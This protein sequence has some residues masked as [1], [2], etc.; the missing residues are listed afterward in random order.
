MEYLIYGF[1]VDIRQYEIWDITF[2]LL[3]VCL[4][5]LT[6]GNYIYKHNISREYLSLIRTGR[7]SQWWYQLYARVLGLDFVLVVLAFVLS[8]TVQAGVWKLPVSQVVGGPVAQAFVL[9]F[10]NICSLSAVQ[11]L[12]IHS[13]KGEKWAFFLMVFV[14][15]LSLYM[16]IEWGYKACWLP[17][18]WKM[19]RR[20]SLYVARG[21]LVMVTTVLQ[22]TV[23]G[24]CWL[25]GW[26]VCNQ[27]K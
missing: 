3:M 12:M 23:I 24:G 25:W 9:F 2:W 6:A 26:R 16:G 1:E 15:A 5:H 19:L 11:M 20:S 7:F 4:M 10:L 8:V 14:E 27:K 18:S 21:Y 13:G 17:G 22:V